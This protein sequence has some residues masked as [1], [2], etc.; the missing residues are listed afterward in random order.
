MSYPTF[1]G[2]NRPRTFL[3]ADQYVCVRCGV[4]GTYSTR[5]NTPKPELCIDCKE[6]ETILARGWTDCGDGT[7][8]GW[9]RH[10]NNKT[11]ACDACKVGRAEH[12]AAKKE[13]AA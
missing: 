1:T 5:R 2:T 9:V 7:Y 4:R 3:K 11:T 12:L 8:A 6:V 10:R 13:K